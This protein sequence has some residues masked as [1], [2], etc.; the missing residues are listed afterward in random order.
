ME[1]RLS[2]QEC[3]GRARRLR[4]TAAKELRPDRRAALL[5]MAREYDALAAAMEKY[6][7]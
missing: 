1:D 6:L 5:K 2:P 7:H 4:E 3:R